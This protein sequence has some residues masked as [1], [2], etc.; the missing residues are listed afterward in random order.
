MIQTTVKI[1]HKLVN[2]TEIARR[3]GISQPYVYALL[4]GK[5]NSQKR[6]EQI[7]TVLKDVIIRIPAA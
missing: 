7:L 6:L 4:T 1:D 2:Q 5:R 3:L